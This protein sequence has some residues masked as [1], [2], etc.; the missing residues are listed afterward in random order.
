LIVGTTA[1]TFAALAMGVATAPAS[2]STVSVGED[3]R[4]IFTAS[5]GERNVIS[6]SSQ[7]LDE[8]ELEDAGSTITA[9]AGCEA[10]VSGGVS[11][12]GYTLEVHAGDQD[13]TVFRR[14]DSGTTSETLYGEEGNDTLAGSAFGGPGNDTLSTLERFDAADGGEGDDLI[15]NPAGAD[16][17]GG[18][19]NDR[20]V[21]HA[22]GDCG[23]SQVVDGGEG[24]D[25]L[26]GSADTETL[27][28][29]PGKDVIS[30][31]GAAY[32]YGLDR[33]SGGPGDDSLTAGGAKRPDSPAFG[34][35]ITGLNVSNGGPRVASTVD[36]GPGDDRLEGGPNRDVLSGADGDD[37]IDGGAGYD[38]LS[39]GT[40]IDSL[41]GGAE[42]DGFDGGPG[43]DVID[44]GP[45]EWDG[46]SYAGEPGPVSIDLTRAGGDGPSGEDDT[47]LPGVDQFVLTVGD[48]RLVAGRLR[49]DVTG[50]FGRDV[51][52]G[53]AGED[54][55]NGDGA[56]GQAPPD[57]DFGADRLEG[58]GGKDDLHGDAGSDVIRG[59]AGDD[60]LDGGRAVTF[61][62][63]TTTRYP[64]DDV[65]S[66]GRGADTV[67]NG[68][69][70]DAG[71][72]DDRIDTADFASQ[73]RSRVIPLGRDG[74]A[75][76][77]PGRD[78][79]RADYY[80]GIGLD[81]EILSEGAA[82]WRSLRPDR[83]GRVTLTVRCAWYYRAPC[84]GSARLVRTPAQTAEAPYRALVQ[85]TT[86]PES[87][88]GCRR[89]RHDL[90]LGAS[91]FRLRAGRV[92]RV[93][94]RLGRRGRRALVRAGCLVVRADLRLRDPKGRPHEVTRTFALRSRSL[95]G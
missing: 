90:V 64:S 69:R 32:E 67:R 21:D 44:G 23:F 62:Q 40:G 4:I 30:G 77:G 68:W 79:V 72:G 36:G 37:Y 45:G 15:D 57:S 22:C 95:R 2:A 12:A 16:V 74:N 55:L 52:I 11:C 50:G 83:D 61:Y 75:R 20:L 84:R 87:P 1:V 89:S 5:P 80:D 42:S 46:I 85:P 49:V 18:G 38:T 6:F 88:E 19:G 47:I 78:F 51:L 8:Y 86:A 25:E 27:V 59:G 53:G 63:G 14:A 24:D 31:G 92:N 33:L 13:D 65:I 54:R 43:S 3:Q 70:V 66:G 60:E 82:S 10:N 7:R 35:P 9:G 34:G 28:G 48:D 39:G 71:P 91:T 81:C 94:V 58:R 93:T 73:N 41:H 17:S 56:S 76:C 26:V 29:G